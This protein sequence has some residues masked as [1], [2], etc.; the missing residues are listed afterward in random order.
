MTKTIVRKA[1]HWSCGQYTPATTGAR[2]KP[3]SMTTAPVTAG[4]RMRWI[5]PAPTMWTSRPTRASTAPETRIAPV[6]A[7]LSPPPARMA[8]TAPTKDALVPR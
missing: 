3:M 8:A 1:T 6:T 4:G 5:T 2:L 7:P